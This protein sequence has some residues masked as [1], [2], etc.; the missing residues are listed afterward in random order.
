MLLD[1][2]VGVSYPDGVQDSQGTI[3]IIY[4]FERTKSKLILMSVFTENDVRVGKPSASTQLRVRV[5]QSTGQAA[6]ASSG[7]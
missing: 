2:R 7:L 3:R 4:D 1:E 5:D 6:K